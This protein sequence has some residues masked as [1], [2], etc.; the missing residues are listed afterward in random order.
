MKYSKSVL[1]TVFTLILSTSLAQAA[2]TEIPQIHVKFSDQS[3]SEARKDFKTNII[4]ASF[5]NTDDLL[6]PPAN[7]FTKVKYPTPLGK[8]S[9]YLTPDPKDGK[10]HPAVIWIHGGYGGNSDSDYLWEPQPKE[11][12]QSGSAFRKAGLVM[13]LP[14]FRG[15][16]GN[17]GKY[18]MFYGELDDLENARAWLAQ[19]PWVD[20]NRIYLAGHSTGGT[21]VLLASEYSDKFRAVFSLGGVADLRTRVENG[22]MIVPVPFNPVAEEYR[23]RSPATFIKSIKKPTFYFEGGEYYWGAFNTVQKFAVENNIPLHI[24]K[25]K[26]ADHFNIID[27]VTKMVAQKILDDDQPQVNITFTE[28]D[29]NKIQQE[30]TQ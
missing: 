18:E 9:A 26:E 8:M 15:E 3:L 17:P 2:I 19:Q 22:K 6:P 25:I 30:A 24:F 23:M 14:S 11:N 20:A 7:I 10:K 12:D 27:P 21:R 29:I 16:D 28:A 1:N 5:D 4:K 13:M